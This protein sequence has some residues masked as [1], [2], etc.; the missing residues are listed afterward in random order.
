MGNTCDTGLANM[1]DPM[2][3][4]I[5][6]FPTVSFK[7]VGKSGTTK[8][9][10]S[11][12]NFDFW[13]KFWFQRKKNAFWSKILFLMKISI[14]G[15]NFDFWSKFSFLVQI[16]SSDKYFDFW[17]KFWFLTKISISDPPN[18]LVPKF[19]ILRVK[20]HIF[21]LKNYLLM[22]VNKTLSKKIIKNTAKSKTLARSIFGYFGI[23]FI[24][25]GH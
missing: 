6:S 15:P 16:L 2:A 5:V 17:S 22:E 23:T 7:N 24:F 9:T 25:S 13:S 14:S 12:Q 11:D 3:P 1:T 20:I 19:S 18:L 4:W 10:I 8:N 21:F